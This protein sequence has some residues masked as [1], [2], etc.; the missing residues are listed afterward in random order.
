M[1]IDNLT[2]IREAIGDGNQPLSPQVAKKARKAKAFALM[3]IE[4]IN[5]IRKAKL[6][7]PAKKK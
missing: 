4:E 6:A 3:I 7:T 5:D 1:S 2:T